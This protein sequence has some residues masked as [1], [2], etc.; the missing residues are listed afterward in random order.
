MIRIVLYAVVLS[1]YVWL[2]KVEIKSAIE[3][4]FKTILVI[5]QTLEYALSDLKQRTRMAQFI[6]IPLSRN[7][8]AIFWNGLMIAL[9]ILAITGNYVLLKGRLEAFTPFE[10]TEDDS[11]LTKSDIVAIL[12][13]FTEIVACFFILEAW[14]DRSFL[15]NDLDPVKPERPSSFVSAMWIAFV[16]I[17]LFTL[18][19]DMAITYY[20]NFLQTNSTLSSLLMTLVTFI[21]SCCFG[22]ISFFCLMPFLIRVVTLLRN[23]L[24]LAI[25]CLAYVVFLVHGLIN[26]SLNFI[27]SVIEIL[28]KIG[29]A[30]VK[31]FRKI[32]HKYIGESLPV[33]VKIAIVLGLIG[34]L[35]FAWSSQQL[36]ISK[37]CVVLLLDL[38]GSFGHLSESCE[39]IE[40]II[41]DLMLGDELHVLSINATSFFDRN[42][43]FTT[44]MPLPKYTNQLYSK[45]YYSYIDSIRNEHSMR[46]RKIAKN[47]KTDAQST[48][49]MGGIAYSTLIF[50]SSKSKHKYLVIYSDLED[51]VAQQCN[52]RLDSVRVWCLYVEHSDFNKY[53]EKEKLWRE[54]F[55]RAGIEEKDIFIRIPA[56]SSG[57]QIK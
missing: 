29:D 46:W 45:E 15:R 50:A 56:Q 28:A 8:V 33:P 14:S 11:F 22:L 47:L 54:Y 4:F 30:M 16:A 51:N 48:D 5:F 55:K 31:P 13:T 18:G 6:D 19:V 39:A 52:V 2:L 36:T 26:N 35:S 32:Q 9:M 7:L 34:L 44:Y 10:I 57:I 27:L 24:S 12:V 25:E 41:G 21:L 53:R 37:K 20:G 42:L 17:Y 38:T 49:I 23:I 3:A 1:F 43:L 40:T